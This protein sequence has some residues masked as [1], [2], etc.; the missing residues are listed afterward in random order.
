MQSGTSLQIRQLCRSRPN[1]VALSLNRRAGR[2]Q[3][4]PKNARIPKDSSQRYN[5]RGE[6]VREAQESEANPEGCRPNN[7]CTPNRSVWWVIAISSLLNMAGSG[8]R[9][10]LTEVVPPC[11][12]RSWKLPDSSSARWG[13]MTSTS[14]L[15]CLPIPKSCATTPSVTPHEAET[16]VQHRPIA[17]PGTVMACGWWWKRPRGGLWDRSACSSSMCSAWKR[18]RS[19]T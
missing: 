7:C 15:P 1:R 18:K 4:L 9:H 14:W 2:S 13:W 8:R 16:W 5:G 10:S 12:S 11:R 17:T 6:G 19:A 3:A